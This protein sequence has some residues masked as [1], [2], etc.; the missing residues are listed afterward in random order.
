MQLQHS[1]RFGLAICLGLLW[2]CQA[3]Y[4]P[5]FNTT[6]AGT[7]KKDGNNDCLPQGI[8]GTYIAGKT[9]NDSSYLLI[10]V[11]VTR[12]GDYKF[13][14]AITDGFSFAGSGRFTVTGLNQVMLKSSGKPDTTGTVDFAIQF[15]TSICHIEIPVSPLIG[16]SEFFLSG[17]PGACLNARD[18]GILASGIPAD[19]S[20][21]LLIYANVTKT[22][23]YSISTDTVNGISY[24]AAGIFSAIGSQQVTL[25]ASGTPQQAGTS[26]FHINNAATACSI[27]VQV[28]NAVIATNNDLFPLVTGSYRT[29]DD[30]Y[31]TGDTVLTTLND[32]TRINGSL[33]KILT[34][35]LQGGTPVQ[36]FYERADSVYLEHTSCDKYTGSVKFSPQIITDLPFLREYMTAGYSWYSDEFV[37]PS[38]FG[39]TIYLRYLFNCLNPDT[40]V[41][42]NGKTFIH[43]CK[44]TL[45]PQIRS[46][47]TYPYNGTGETLECWYA[48][49]I[50]LIYSKA[51]TAAST[52]FTTAERQIRY[53]LIP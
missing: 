30:L 37:G 2:G 3:K 23:Y 15:D 16:Q 35:T 50:G 28:E 44:V 17:S 4:M 25:T 40:R 9:L 20:C 22:G 11:N 49:G 13:Q 39:Q 36:S 51:T 29:Y 12:T 48:K 6:A 18:S 43:V 45:K 32:S 53:W 21:A 42:I 52:T 8:Y 46:A 34:E 47:P 1:I 31:F 5:G 10:S 14:T 38:S 41:T 27:S 19:S 33:Y 26:T 7:L 24:H